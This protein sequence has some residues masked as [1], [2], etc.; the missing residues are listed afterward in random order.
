[1]NNESTKRADLPFDTSFFKKEK[2]NNKSYSPVESFKMIY[3]TNHWKD[4]VSASGNGSN[5]IQTITIKDALPNL[6]KNYSI[7]TLLDLPCGD[8]YWLKNVDL[9]V[10]K[11]YGGDIVKEIIEKNVSLYQ[12]DN[13]KFEVINLI[14]DNLPFVDLIFCRDCLVHL[15]NDD[16]INSIRNIKRSGIK[17]LLTTTFTSCNENED[18]VTGDWRIINLEK[19]PFNFPKPLT[20]INENCME[21]NGTYS[22]KSL[23]LWLVQQINL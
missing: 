3:Q 20:V 4:D 6:F 9:G 5:D 8:F 22:D 21:G 16:L 19:T 11:Y 15:S 7:K 17:Y 13:R 2:L 23:G 10:D 1:M 18:I 12:N 14:S